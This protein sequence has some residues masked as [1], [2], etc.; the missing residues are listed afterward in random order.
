M[1]PN[2]Q[3][4]FFQTHDRAIIRAIC[5]AAADR[6]GAV[7]GIF[8]DKE[9]A[10]DF[11]TAYYTDYEPQSCLVAVF[12]GDVVGYLTGCVDNRRY[13]LLMGSYLL[14]KILVCAFFRGALFR[15]EF[16]SLAQ[17]AFKNWRRWFSWRRDSFHSHQGHL[18]IG[19]SETFRH[20]GIGEQLV[21]AFLN[22]ARRSAVSQLEASVHQGN[23]F[24]CRFFERMGFYVAH[25]HHMWMA[26][27]SKFEQYQAFNYVKDV[28]N[29]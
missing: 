25:R 24:G 27:G 14:P 1:D 20:K 21:N 16:W 8:P 11:L 4:R 2:I 29:T 19:I 7:E 23:V 10:A 12:D 15:P 9:I 18:H 26:R 22:H 3:I 6:G 28:S 17:A 5:C 13:G